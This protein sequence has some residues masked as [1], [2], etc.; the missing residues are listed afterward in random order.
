MPFLSAQPPQSSRASREL[1]GDGGGHWYKPDG[2]PLHT[3]KSAE[4]NDRNT[5]LA[6]ARKLGLYP[7]VTTITKVIA[8]NSLDRWKQAQMLNACS[9]NPK[10]ESED[11][12]DYEY[13]MRQ[14]AQKKMVDARAF[15]SLFHSAIDELNKTG[16][17][18]EKYEEIK[19]FV[20]HYIQW[21][22]DLSIQFIDTEFVAVNNK[23]GYAGQVDALAI[24][25]GKLTLLDYKTQDVKKTGKDGEL[26]PNYYSSWVWQLAAYKNA[27]W[28]NKPKRISQV[29][30]VVLCSQEPCYPITKI[31]SQEEIADA[32]RLFQH[33]NA[34]W[35]L[36]NKFDPVATAKEKSDG[37]IAA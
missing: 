1:N 10:S 9:A 2:C 16:F 8:N 26:K 23:L 5:T 29:M 36:L 21:T 18:T 33:A 20:K 31:W 24:V 11:L 32:W 4:G 34:I 17:L 12:A 19:P 6:D 37:K 15:G 30:S 35:Q 7:S 14:L 28:P 27:D 3:V 22:R 25:D 13:R